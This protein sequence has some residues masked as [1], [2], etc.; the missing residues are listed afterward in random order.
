MQKKEKQKMKQ[1][2]IQIKLTQTSNFILILLFLTIG[3]TLINLS[4][5][6]GILGGIMLTEIIYYFKTTKEKQ[7]WEK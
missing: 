7:K 3:F 6:A 2:Q 1:L 5:F 4:F